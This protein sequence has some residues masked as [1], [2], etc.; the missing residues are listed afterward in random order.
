MNLLFTNP[1]SASLAFHALSVSLEVELFYLQKIFT[2]LPSSNS[3]SEV[4]PNDLSYLR[5][6]TNSLFDGM[7][8][9]VNKFFLFGLDPAPWKSASVVSKISFR[10]FTKPILSL[11]IT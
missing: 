4:G 11:D 3:V 7:S 10:S 8:A 5:L 2:L 6:G 1:S 9:P